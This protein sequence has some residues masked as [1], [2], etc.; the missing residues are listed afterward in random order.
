MPTN[1]TPE[2]KKAEEAYREAKTLDE[3]IERLQDMISLLPKH[4]GTD[5]LYADLKRRLARMKRELEQ[6]GGRRGGGQALDFTREGAAQVILIGPPNS[7]KSSI[8]R[9]IT[10]AHPDVGDY[11]F[12]TSKPLPGMAP[13]QDIQI[14]IID[15]PPVTGDFMHMHLLGLVRSADGV[16]IVA[17]LSTDS[18]LDD[19]EGLFDAFRERHVEFV[20]RKNPERRDEIL[21]RI[22]ANKADVP[23]AGERLELLRDL[24]GDRLDILP[25]S[26]LDE[27]EVRRIPEQLFQW[28]GIR[29]VYSKIPGKKADMEHPFTVF[30][31]GTVDDICHLVHKDFVKSLKFA[32]LW[33]KSE[34]PLTV[35]RHEPVEDGDILELHL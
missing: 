8:L 16:L 25:L 26:C 17:D 24:I 11:P 3:R 6:S 14:Q 21:S 2:Y 4:K 35:S 28:L 15:T 34:R 33:R 32:R 1:V 5:H 10:H 29:R 27:E 19:L 9:A 22:M 23:D 7:G 31:G 20:G 30:T 12:T 13:F 18:L